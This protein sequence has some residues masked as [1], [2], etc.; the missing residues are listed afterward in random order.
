MSKLQVWLDRSKGKGD[1]SALGKGK[2]RVLEAGPGAT[3]QEPGSSGQL[4]WPLFSRQLLSPLIH[5]ASLP[6]I[7]GSWAAPRG[8]PKFFNPAKAGPLPSGEVPAF[9]GTFSFSSGLPWSTGRRAGPRRA[10]KRW[11]GAQG[12]IGRWRGCQ[13]RGGSRAWWGGG[14]GRGVGAEM[15]REG[16]RWSGGHLPGTPAPS[17]RRPVSASDPPEQHEECDDQEVKDELSHLHH[18]QHRGAKPQAPLA[19]QVGQEGD[20]L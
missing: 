10:G 13:G 20:H 14:G 5:P 17:A 11:A 16:G 18:R 8:I 6:H 9:W 12:G 15:G 7:K 4:P 2:Q 3:G 19:A 1:L